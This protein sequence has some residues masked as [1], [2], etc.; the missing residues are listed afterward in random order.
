MEHKPSME[1][2]FPTS[3]SVWARASEISKVGELKTSEDH[4]QIVLHVHKEAPPLS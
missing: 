2:V 4:T 3:G 1:R